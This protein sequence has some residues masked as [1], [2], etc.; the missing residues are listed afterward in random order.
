M[1][2][3]NCHSSKFNNNDDKHVI[4]GDIRIV[5]NNK[6]RKLLYECINNW[7]IK[8]KLNKLAFLPWK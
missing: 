1:F 5:K 7:S 2:P 6:L 4:S 3:C 8:S